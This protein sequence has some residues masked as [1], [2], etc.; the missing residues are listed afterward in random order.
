MSTVTL[1][2][3]GTP[4]GSTPWASSDASV[5]TITSSGVVTGCSG[6]YDDDYVYERQRL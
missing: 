6:G 5:A 3:S 2:G 1:T 4:A